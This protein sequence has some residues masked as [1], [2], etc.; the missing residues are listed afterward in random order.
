MPCV[1]TLKK[2]DIKKNFF[3]PVSLFVLVSIKDILIWSLIRSVSIFGSY[4]SEESGSFYG[5]ASSQVISVVE[6]VGQMA[7]QM[8]VCK[9][10]RALGIK[11]SEFLL[12]FTPFCQQHSSHAAPVTEVMCLICSSG[13]LA[14]N[15]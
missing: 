15:I 11:V 5:A 13:E 7:P 6:G 3:S 14:V 12:P 9:E 8:Q 1:G 10:K 2:T 4:F